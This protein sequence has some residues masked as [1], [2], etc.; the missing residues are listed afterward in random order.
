MDQLD[1]VVR[2]FSVTASDVSRGRRHRRKFTV[3]RPRPGSRFPCAAFT[4]VS[5]V[6]VRL[7]ACAAPFSVMRC[8]LG[9]TAIVGQRHAAEPAHFRRNRLEHLAFHSANSAGNCSS[10]G[11]AAG[12][13]ILSRWYPSGASRSDPVLRSL[14]HDESTLFAMPSAPRLV[15]PGMILGD[16]KPSSMTKLA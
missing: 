4:M 5:A 11:G 12:A 10:S 8:T 2:G 13:I 16:H 3:P 7:I 14:S 15:S 9:R 1:P 6:F